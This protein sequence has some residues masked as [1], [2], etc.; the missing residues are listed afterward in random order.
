M[1]THFFPN[2]VKMLFFFLTPFFLHDHSSQLGD[3]LEDEVLPGYESS[4]LRATVL[5]KPWGRMAFGEHQG[6]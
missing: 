3:T 4:A 2:G 5:R 1:Y 6:T